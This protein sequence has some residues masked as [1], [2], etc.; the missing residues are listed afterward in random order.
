MCLMIARTRL[1][2]GFSQNR[3]FTTYAESGM[4]MM[5]RTY[6]EGSFDCGSRVSL[7]VH[8][9]Q[10]VEP[11]ASLTDISAPY[12]PRRRTG[13]PSRLA[14]GQ[15]AGTATGAAL[16]GSIWFSLSRAICSRFVQER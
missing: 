4:S 7:M 10:Q 9:C 13:F 1:R 3:A 8:L 5:G 15:N 12:T 14:W 2:E 11:R 16:A 6:L